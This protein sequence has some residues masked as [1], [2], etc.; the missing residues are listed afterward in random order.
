MLKPAFDTKGIPVAISCSNRYVPY[1]SVLLQSIIENMSPERKYDII[2]LNK[3]FSDRN[4]W[5]LE[6]Q[7]AFPNMSIRFFDV[8]EYTSGRSFYTSGLSVEA[9]F[10]MFLVDV[11]SEYDKTIYLDVDIV[12]NID[13]GDIYDIDIEDNYIGAAID[14]NI[15]SSY[16]SKNHWKPYIDNVLKLK[17]PL[18][19]VQ[20]GVMII[21]LKK[22]RENFTLEYLVN[23]CT[24]REW[25]LFDQDILNSLC[26]GKIYFLD[27]H[28]NVTNGLEKRM[29]NINC[30]APTDL[31]EQWFEARKDPKIVHFIGKRKPWLAFEIE[32]AEYFWEYAKRSMFYQTLIVGR[33]YSVEFDVFEKR[34]KSLENKINKL[35]TTA[36]SSITKTNLKNET[37]PLIK[38]SIEY[39]ELPAARSCKAK[40][41]RVQSVFQLFNAINIVYNTLKNVPVDIMLTKAT[42][43]SKYINAIRDSKL[44]RNVIVSEDTPETYINWR[45]VSKNKQEDICRNPEKYVYLP[46]SESDYL[47]LYIAVADEYNKILYYYLVKNGCYPKIHMFED[48][49]N[50]Y[51]L[52]NRKKCSE[53]FILH[54]IYGH[55]SFDKN[56]VESLTYEPAAVICKYPDIEYSRIP[57]LAL[58]NSPLK[59]IYCNIFPATSFP[60][61]KYIF[62]EEAFFCDGI[63]STDVELV[64][65]LADMVG[66]ENIVVKLHPRNTVDRFSSRGF[67][68]MELSE[69]PWE[70]TIMKSDLSDKVFVT[71]SSTAALTSG[72]VFNKKFTAIN[73]FKIITVGKNIHVRQ[74]MYKDFYSTI[75][76]MLNYNQK[77]VFTPNSIEEF[78]EEIIYIQRGVI[79][80]GYQKQT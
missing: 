71:V 6:K 14:V 54:E 38:A 4:K 39:M 73:L 59:K 55:A 18:E 45:S 12:T 52:D 8:N 13:I 49:M 74:P 22:M 60:K 25:R 46:K 78:K 79:N 35:S 32:F 11:M 28:F 21:N 9:Y 40:L 23:L 76:S 58:N 19:Y 53:D 70:M 3:D 27:M 67:T 69:V 62:L 41:F 50:S 31:K 63:T 65:Y 72:L 47:D 42:D 57:K 64:E 7:C 34:I 48:G 29:E 1:L 30:Y 37:K 36:D 43:F 75:E 26:Q 16:I 20:S 68:V 51:I 66:I 15:V 80:N 2:I 56:I 10:R 44:F 33:L 61:Q 5:I 24:E 77:Q 17:N